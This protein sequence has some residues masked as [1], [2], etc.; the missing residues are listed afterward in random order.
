MYIVHCA[1]NKM[2]QVLIF[3]SGYGEF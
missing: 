3:V 1:V 2:M